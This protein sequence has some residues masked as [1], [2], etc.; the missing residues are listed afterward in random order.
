MSDKS[1]FVKFLVRMDK[2][3]SELLAETASIPFSK[4]LANCIKIKFLRK[5]MLV[6][7]YGITKSEYKTILK[8]PNFLKHN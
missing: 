1:E 5:A 3:I 6:K 8:H 2:P 4:R 7:N